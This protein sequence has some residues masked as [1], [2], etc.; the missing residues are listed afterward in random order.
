V[1]TLFRVEFHMAEVAWSARW[2]GEMT[3]YGSHD[4][5]T[6]VSL[7]SSVLQWEGTSAISVSS[8]TSAALQAYNAFRFEIQ[9]RYPDGYGDDVAADKISVHE[10]LLFGSRP[11][12]K[13]CSAASED[14]GATRAC[15][16]LGN[17]CYEMDSHFAQCRSTCVEGVDGTCKVLGGQLALQSELG[18]ERSLVFTVK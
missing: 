5:R 14:C 6:W 4:K 7:W 3:V 15:C 18:L 13:T 11:E 12:S 16:D 2:P 1:S 10:L 17:T 8:N 9:N